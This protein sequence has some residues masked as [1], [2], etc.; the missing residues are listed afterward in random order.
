MAPMLSNLD[1][2]LSVVFTEVH[3]R[4]ISMI[5]DYVH[6]HSFGRHH[7]LEVHS[8]HSTSH[9]LSRHSAT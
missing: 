2:A 5:P 6:S 7:V 9:N 1:S 8:I 4:M 3:V